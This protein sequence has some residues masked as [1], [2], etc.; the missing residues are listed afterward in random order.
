MDQRCPGTGRQ[1]LSRFKVPPNLIGCICLKADEAG[2]SGCVHWSAVRKTAPL[3][4][5]PVSSPNQEA[6]SGKL[7]FP[8]Y[9]PRRRQVTQSQ[10]N[11]T[12]EN[13]I[14]TKGLRNKASRRLMALVF[15]GC[16]QIRL[17]AEN[18]RLCFEEYPCTHYSLSMIDLLDLPVTR[19][20]DAPV[21]SM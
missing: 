16:K 1:Y 10:L 5:S 18:L 6:F 11:R 3:R 9:D 13:G 8:S 12:T 4:D 21:Q 15:R 14:G 17:K 20:S 2:P 7:N 19:R